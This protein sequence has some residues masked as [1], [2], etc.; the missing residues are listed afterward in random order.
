MKTWERK[1]SEMDQVELDI[2]LRSKNGVS[3]HHPKGYQERVLQQYEALL[4][5]VA[6]QEIIV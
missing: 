3:K 4:S 5:N 1:F 6:N 2:K